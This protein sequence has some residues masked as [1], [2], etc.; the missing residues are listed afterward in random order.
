MEAAVALT[1]DA[2][3]RA[4]SQPGDGG[5]NTPP[6]R[7]V[8]M[9]YNATTPLE[10]EVIQVMTEAM[11]EAWGNPSSPYPTVQ[12]LS[13]PFR[14]AALPAHPQRRGGRG[15][16]PPRHLHRG[17]RLHPPAPGAPGEGAGGRTENTPMI[18]GLGKAAELVTKNCEAY[19]AHMRDVRDYLEERLLAEFD[20]Q[21]IHLNSRFPGT[22]RLP[23]TCN[24]SIRG[25]Q[26]QGRVLLAQCRTL[27]ASVGAACHS[28][29]VDRPSPVLLSCGIPFDVARN[30]L[31]LSVGRSTTRAEVDLVVQDLKQAVAL[32]EGPPGARGAS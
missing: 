22:E 6:E 24:F 7:K 15:R 8:Y 23:N 13:N 25:P 20:K 3:G 28:D 1:G 12:Q 14:G 16:A 10:P 19:E 27:L 21:R 30:A 31:R 26:L 29:Q 2:R 9:D 17:T 18:A 5:E 4:A 11:R 32:L